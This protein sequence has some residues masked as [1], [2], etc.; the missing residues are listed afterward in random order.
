MDFFA[1]IFTAQKINIAERKTHG[2][3]EA[4]YQY[5]QILHPKPNIPKIR[6][7]VHQ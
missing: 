6:L 2:L 7:M 1:P 5:T 3:N 4:K